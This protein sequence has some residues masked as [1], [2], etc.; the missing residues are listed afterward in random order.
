MSQDEKA[1]KFSANTPSN[2]QLT[3]VVKSAR[4][5]NTYNS[6]KASAATRVTLAESTGSRPVN[7][8]RS[9]GVG[10]VLKDRFLL[11]YEIARGGMGVV[12]RARDLLKEKYQDRHPHVAVKVL[13]EQYKTHPDAFMAL[14]REAGKAQK[15]AHP[16]IC[17]VYDFDHDHDVVF[18][19]ME[20]LE[21][22][23]LDKIIETQQ[24]DPLPQKNTLGI[25]ESMSKGLTYAHSKGI[26][27]SDFKPGNVMMMTD[28]SVK[29]LD[30]GIASISAQHQKKTQE[31]TLFDPSRRLGAL[32]PAYASCEMIEWQ[33]PDPRDDI[34]ALA[35]VSYELLSG[36]HPFNRVQ[37]TVARD[38]G[39]KPMSIKGLNKQQWKAL[40]RGL[41]FDRKARTSSAE[42]FMSELAASAPTRNRLVVAAMAVIFLVAGVSAYHVFEEVS[43]KGQVIL[44]HPLSQ[45]D[46]EK[47]SRLAEAAQ[48]HFMVGRITDPPG[49]NAFAAYEQI[50]EIDPGDAQALD[51]MKKIADHYETLARTSWENGN[52]EQSRALIETGFG[53]VPG[54]KGLSRL[55]N[56]IE[57][58]PTWGRRIT[59]WLRKLG[60]H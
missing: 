6:D 43:S 1:R 44:D 8:D 42:Q 17:T 60:A 41:T 50:L 16:N 29:I 11:E 4:S 45:D 35:C 49:S 36:R 18:M 32:T 9:V 33:E 53:V 14:Q 13:A 39:L 24:S 58:Q 37:A 51:G 55:L 52:I 2:N 21:G 26:V 23:T 7:I 47:I 59:Q 5:R 20:Y 40:Q 15:L 31:A 28:G 54:H 3:R 46:Q 30:F 57:P 10:S 27:H 48:V 38:A 12:Y 22:Q 19:T 34:Y 25:I 56:E